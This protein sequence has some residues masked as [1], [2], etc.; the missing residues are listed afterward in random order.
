M[1]MDV[2]LSKSGTELD[3]SFDTASSTSTHHL[4]DE[5][6]ICQEEF[7]RIFGSSIPYLLEIANICLDEDDV[8]DKQDEHKK[9]ENKR[10]KSGID[11]VKDRKIN[12]DN[13]NQHIIPIEEC[14]KPFREEFKLVNFRYFYL[15]PIQLHQG[16][17]KEDYIE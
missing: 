2:T 8:F 17:F 10:G 1:G 15:A 16:G 5:S 9:K 6:I 4:S 14:A 3:S 12:G 11:M 13:N 7:D